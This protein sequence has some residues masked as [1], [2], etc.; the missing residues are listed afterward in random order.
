MYNGQR[1]SIKDFLK[2]VWPFELYF[3]L[4]CIHSDQTWRIFDQVV[5]TYGLSQ[6]KEGIVINCDKL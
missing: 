4:V 2:I 5:L 3:I 6:G 1:Y